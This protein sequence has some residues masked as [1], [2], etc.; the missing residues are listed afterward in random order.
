MADFE[1]IKARMRAFELTVEDIQEMSDEFF[2]GLDAEE[3]EVF[4]LAMHHALEDPK[5]CHELGAKIQVGKLEEKVLGV[6]EA[7]PARQGGIN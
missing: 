2:A 5:L 3:R 4:E 1:A 6:S 7:P